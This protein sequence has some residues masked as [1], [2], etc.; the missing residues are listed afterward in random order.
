VLDAY[1]ELLDY[2]RE[3]TSGADSEGEGRGPL[4]GDTI[5]M[6]LRGQLR[7]LATD[8]VPDLL[9]ESQLVRLSEIGITASREGRLTISDQD[10]FEEAL[11]DRPDEVE[12]LFADEDEGVAVRTVELIDR[13]VNAGGLLAS[14]RQLAQIRQ[15]TLDQRIERE[16]TYLARREE[17]L[18]E[19]LAALQNMMYQLQQQQQILESLGY[20]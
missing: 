9:G 2:V 10:A 11:L 6:T 17:Q 15:R 14:Q 18:A 12:R 3:K 8:A 16:E 20:V 5:F 7:S 4:T 1:N 13:Y 19:Q